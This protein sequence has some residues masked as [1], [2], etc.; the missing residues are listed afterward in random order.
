MEEYKKQEFTS[1]LAAINKQAKQIIAYEKGAPSIEI[2]ILKEQLR[3]FYVEVEAQK[4]SVEDKIEDKAVVEEKV[5]EKVEV[6]V[7]EKVEAKDFEPMSKLFITPESEEVEGKEALQK[8]PDTINIPKQDNAPSQAKPKI[9][10]GL[11][12]QVEPKS[13]HQLAAEK[14]TE[15]TL[16]ENIQSNS[17]DSLKKYIGIN[18][19]FQF[20]NELFD[21]K[22]KIYNE[23]IEKLD[24]LSEI[25]TA[26]QFLEPMQEKY[27][28]DMKSPVYEQFMGYLTKRFS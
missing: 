4:F 10:K 23:T 2:D 5:E 25:K 17:I 6:E 28:W 26:N 11:A 20:I 14:S 12:D 3:K 15:K 27:S 24:K 13:I 8:K 18:D 9:N 7:E 1:L 19:K 16:G 21:G 22:M